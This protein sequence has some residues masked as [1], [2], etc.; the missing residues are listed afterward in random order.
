MHRDLRGGKGTTDPYA[1]SE[2]ARALP[3]KLSDTQAQ[4]AVEPVLA[5]IKGTTPD[6]LRALAKTLQTLAPKLSDTQA[7]AAIE[8]VL[9][10]IKATTDSYAP[11]AL[12]QALQALAPKL[13]D[14]QKQLATVSAQG[15]L[16]W[17]PTMKPAEAWAR[18]LAVL[19]P[20]DPEARYAGEIVEPLKYPT[21]A[22]PATDAL[23][24]ALHDRL[25]G[26]ADPRARRG[27][28]RLGPWAPK[29][30]AAIATDVLD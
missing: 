6:A 25:P 29:G 15:V 27:S 3:A 23:L 10:A 17:A 24:D 16:G 4:A 12:A 21:T 13:S 14:M 18:V 11:G 5:A 26:T 30:P 8:P 22:G 19:L 1:L 20:R 7:Q 9:A 2:L 28:R